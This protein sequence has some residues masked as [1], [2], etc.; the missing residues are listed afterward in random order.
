MTDTR[1]R[2]LIVALL[3]LIVAERWA[4]HLLPAAHAEPAPPTTPPATC[5]L[6]RGT[7]GDTASLLERTNR[8]LVD[9]QTIGLKQFS[10]LN[11]SG[12]WDVLVCG[13]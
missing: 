8:S 9:L 3:V 1:F 12:G 5:T 2:T 10:F 11:L 7:A 6:V 4:P 13:W